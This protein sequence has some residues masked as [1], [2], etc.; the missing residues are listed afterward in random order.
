METPHTHTFILRTACWLHGRLWRHL[1]KLPMPVLFLVLLKKITSHALENMYLFKI[2]TGGVIYSLSFSRPSYNLLPIIIL[3]FGVWFLKSL[4]ALKFV[5]MDVKYHSMFKIANKE[6]RYLSQKDK[7]V[8]GTLPSRQS[9]GLECQG[10][11]LP[12]DGS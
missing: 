2:C 8:G 9:E 1:S 3:S 7:Y 12:T 5:W 4:E 6:T 11:K 10:S